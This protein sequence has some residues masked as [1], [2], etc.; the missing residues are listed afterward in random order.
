MC[1]ERLATRNSMSTHRIAEPRL[2]LSSDSASG[3]G[4]LWIHG[5]T[6]CSEI[7]QV[8]WHALSKF[9][10]F[11][12]DLPA[13][14]NAPPLGSEQT[15]TNWCD[16]LARATREA[17][18]RHI[19]ALSFGGLIAIILASQLK[20]NLRTLT[21]NSPAIPGASSDQAV[22]DCNLD[23]IRTYRRLGLGPWL[24]QT[25]ID[26]PHGI[27]SGVK[28]RP[29][30]WQALSV[31]LKKHSW[32]ELRDG[33]INRM[34]AAAISKSVMREISAQTLVV[35]GD[36]DIPV[37]KRNAHDIIRE[38]PRASRKHISGCG[39]LAFLEEPQ[40]AVSMIADHLQ[41]YQKRR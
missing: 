2:Y 6:M 26:W 21:L 16:D 23:L 30:Q 27:F 29:E 10:H 40:L 14:G 5:Y 31:I 36:D 37:F 8:H 18:V 34:S 41:T 17:D 25:W 13:H 19:V 4:I 20:D 33:S 39:H 38:V 28:R 32:E 7:W 3:E 22:Q 9:R 15:L 35:I 12:V 1:T 11:A 24:T